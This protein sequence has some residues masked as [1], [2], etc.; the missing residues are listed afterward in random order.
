M[1]CC[2][3]P[4]PRQ[5]LKSASAAAMPA[6]VSGTGAGSGVAL[7]S[8]VATLSSPNLPA[9]LDRSIFEAALAQQGQPLPASSPAAS[10]VA[11]N[12]LA[13][14]TPAASTPA[15]SPLDPHVAD[16]LQYL[17]LSLLSK[18]GV[19]AVAPAL[20]LLLDKLPTLK[21]DSPAIAIALGLT[22]AKQIDVAAASGNLSAAIANILK[23][24]APPAVGGALA[25]D[26]ATLASTLT[27][28]SQLLLLQTGLA[29]LGQALNTPQLVGQLLATLDNAPLLQPAL[30]ASQQTTLLDVLNNIFSVNYLKFDLGNTKNNLDGLKFDLGNQLVAQVFKDRT[31]RKA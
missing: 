21:A 18:I 2:P 3:R 10:P 13:A 25:P 20:K 17:N 9:I 30:A 29:Q 14:S 28:V 24:A 6:Q 8:I 27:A 31:M 16:K 23:S 7:T 4:T 1:P 15:A 22:F 26:L 11:V 19:A 5:R 12:P